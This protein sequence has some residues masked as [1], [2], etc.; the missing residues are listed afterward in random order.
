MYLH[1]NVFDVSKNIMKN[2][3]AAK[4]TGMIF[5][6]LNWIAQKDMRPLLSTWKGKVGD[7]KQSE[8]KCFFRPKNKFI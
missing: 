5:G 3:G 1:Q 7:M 8:Q 6:L 2:H 4:L